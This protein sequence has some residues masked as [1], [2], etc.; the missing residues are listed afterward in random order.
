MEPDIKAFSMTLAPLKITNSFK[1]ISFVSNPHPSH[2]AVAAKLNLQ[3]VSD[4]AGRP[5]NLK[6]T[7]ETALKVL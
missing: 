3:N 7:G 4:N 6:L 1:K 5:T 2:H